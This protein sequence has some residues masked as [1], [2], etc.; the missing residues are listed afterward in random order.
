MHMLAH[1][2]PCRWYRIRPPSKTLACSVQ[3]DRVRRQIRLV[4]MRAPLCNVM[5]SR[6]SAC[7]ACRAASPQSPFSKDAACPPK[8]VRDKQFDPYYEEFTPPKKGVKG[9]RHLRECDFMTFV[10]A[11]KKDKK[12]ALVNAPD[13]ALKTYPAGTRN[14]KLA[15][16]YE[17]TGA[18][19]SHFSPAT[20]TYTDERTLD[21]EGTTNPEAQ[22]AIDYNAALANAVAGL[23]ALPR[24]WEASL[25]RDFRGGCPDADGLKALLTKLP[26]QR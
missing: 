2:C 23:A 6:P 10:G 15:N 16:S 26:K 13:T 14:A 17:L 21:A 11:P 7:G 24:D 9:V 12:A 4:R 8:E 20:G 1:L 3:I 25:G 22:V 5:A 19:V 18:L